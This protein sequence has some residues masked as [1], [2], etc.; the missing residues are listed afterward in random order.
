MT[1]LQ[2][3]DHFPITQRD[4]FAMA[5]SDWLDAFADLETGIAKC[6][7]RHCAGKNKKNLSHRLDDLAALEAGP[8]LSCHQ[9]GR[10]GALVVQCREAMLL[11]GTLVH[12]QM[13]IGL[14]D[15]V[16]VALFVNVAAEAR[17]ALGHVA[18]TQQ[19][20]THSIEELHRLSAELQTFA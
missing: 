7:A 9:Q 10:L 6:F 13:R 4:P 1:A 20:F 15:E 8:N 11:R 3:A 2:S 16:T 14:I 17:K 19:Q 12:S 18:L 5:R